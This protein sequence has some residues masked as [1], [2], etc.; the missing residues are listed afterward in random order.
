MRRTG[1]AARGRPAAESAVR[2]EVLHLLDDTFGRRNWGHTGLRAATRG[3]GVAEASW[4]PSGG[5]HSIW[6]QLN[7][8][9]HWRRHVRARLL[10]RH[11]RTSQAWP[12]GGTTAAELRRTL[13]GLAA[14]HRQFRAA[15]L[16]LP[17]GPLTEKRGSRY[18]L[19]QLLLAETAHV[20]YH[21][22]QVLLMRR[23]YRHRR[24]MRS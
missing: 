2:E 14:L 23:L 20:S 8:I 12:R 7:H 22:G 13:A 3:L 17:P 6:Q 1:R 10:G 21:T 18:A 5:V 16:R 15:V 11:P 19:A 4:T 24:R 9:A